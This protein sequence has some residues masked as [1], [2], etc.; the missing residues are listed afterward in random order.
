MSCAKKQAPSVIEKMTS[1]S[2]RRPW[3]ALALVSALGAAACSSEIPL[4]RL[5]ERHGLYFRDGESR[6]FS[7]QATDRYHGGKLRSRASFRAGKMDGVA[8]SWHEN[9]RL[10]NETSF[11]A[12]ELHGPQTRWFVSGRVRSQGRFFQN[13]MEGA[14]KTWDEQGI[15]RQERHYANGEAHGIWQEWSTTGRLLSLYRF[16]GGAYAGVQS[17]WHE[18]GKLRF[19]ATARG[20][21]CEGNWRQWHPDGTPRLFGQWQNGL[22]TGEWREWD[23]SGRLVEIIRYDAGEPVLWRQ[24]HPGGTL[25]L[26]ARLEAKGGPWAWRAWK[27]DGREEP[28]RDTPLLRGLYP[29]FFAKSGAPVSGP[30]TFEQQGSLR[31]LRQLSPYP[32]FSMETWGKG[33]FTHFLAGGI[34][35]SWTGLPTAIDLRGDE[36]E[37]CSTFMVRQRTGGAIF[38]HNNDHRPYAVM[39]LRHFPAGGYASISV[40]NIPSMNYVAAN[41]GLAR[42]QGQAA[43]LR[44]PFYPQEGMNERGVA[45]SGMSSPG[46][47]RLI[48]PRRATLSYE[49]IMRLVLD[50]AA[51]VDEALLLLGSYNL[52]QSNHQHLLVADSSGRSAVVEFFDG[53][54][55]VIANDA[56][57]QVATNF[58][59]YGRTLEQ[60]RSACRRFDEAWRRFERQ[61]GGFTL[62]EAMEVL[63]AISMVEPL[64]TVTSAAYDLRGGRMLLALGRD[65]RRT[66]SFLLRPEDL[67]G[68]C[69]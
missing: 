60:R 42:F 5:R 19:Q 30:L 40:V 27:R 35:G 59:L 45:I 3:L 38:G 8:R 54:M 13:R 67:W 33:E 39:V 12:G 29:I 37:M 66:W 24:W 50:H 68:R 57:W 65:F 61:L 22:R 11:A 49:Q 14:W 58:P 32:L 63:S 9:G 28:R 7:G 17:Q 15:L 26:Q 34:P 69:L 41:P 20:E 53:R 18:H 56:E 43:L 47:E 25:R 55:K 36:P 21:T 31:T 2:G 46:Q 4:S 62:E 16:A 52:A 6:P 1:V 44:A 23:E 48:D 51:D 10:Q 64:E